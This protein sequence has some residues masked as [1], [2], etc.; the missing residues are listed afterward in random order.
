M[1]RST[2]GCIEVQYQPEVFD[3]Y[4]EVKNKLQLKLQ[5]ASHLKLMPLNMVMSS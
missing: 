3:E 4:I 1:A 5:L 2:T